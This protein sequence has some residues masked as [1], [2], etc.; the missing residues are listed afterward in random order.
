MITWEMIRDL[1][2]HG[3]EIME[4]L[5]DS[6]RDA[7][8]AGGD[9]GPAVA[10]TIPHLIARIAELDNS[11]SDA[12]VYILGLETRLLEAGLSFAEP[13]TDIHGNSR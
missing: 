6:I 7:L 5:Q 13:D 10:L 8:D 9:P 11:L 1:N 4:D 12:K 2:A 3:D